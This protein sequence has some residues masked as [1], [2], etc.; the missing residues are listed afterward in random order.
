MCIVGN[1]PRAQVA[2]ETQPALWGRPFE[3]GA[4]QAKCS[5]IPSGFDRHDPT[6]DVWWTILPKDV[7]Y[8]VA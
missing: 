4:Y 7:I 3:L 8:L 5:L 6:K 2:L 1:D